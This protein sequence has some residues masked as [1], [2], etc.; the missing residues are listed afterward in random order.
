MRSQVEMRQGRMRRLAESRASIHEPVN[1]VEEVEEERSSGEGIRPIG[2]VEPPQNEDGKKKIGK[3]KLSRI[4]LVRT[5]C[6]R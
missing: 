3:P 5:W 6:T 4:P 1:E 2:E